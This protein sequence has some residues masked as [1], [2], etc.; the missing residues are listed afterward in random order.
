MKEVG[1]LKKGKIKNMLVFCSVKTE[2]ITV[3]LWKHLF[4]PQKLKVQSSQYQN[5]EWGPMNEPTC[6][7]I[8]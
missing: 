6:D 7:L 8:A 1:N 5:I 3:L 4:V 2:I